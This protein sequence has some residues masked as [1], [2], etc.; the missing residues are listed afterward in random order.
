MPSFSE[1]VSIFY[2]TALV[3]AFLA[4]LWMSGRFIRRAMLS[5]R[6]FRP[7]EDKPQRLA[8]RALLVFAWLALG[9]LLAAPFRDLLLL[10]QSLSTLVFSSDSSTRLV[11][12]WGSAPPQLDSL[13]LL[14]LMLVVYAI[15]IW[16]G[17]IILSGHERI[18]NSQRSDDSQRSGE[19]KR[20]DEGKR[21]GVI[22]AIAA[23]GLSPAGEFYGLL[24]LAA[25]A[26]RAL[27]TLIVQVV[28][29]QL[30]ASHDR[31]P[32][33]FL[34]GWLVG[35]LLLVVLASFLFNRVEFFELE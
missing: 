5:L 7:V 30:P 13:M 16:A 8:P 21:S 1:L 11:T 20:S 18:G 10:L 23:L 27:Q 26:N 28:W 19:G 17:R 24:T 35:L 29:V 14:L 31:G 12:F 9:G 33:G 2:N 32:L 34:A 15:V 22:P 25:L 3:L 6:G 4:G